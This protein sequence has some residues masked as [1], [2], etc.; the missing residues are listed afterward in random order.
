MSGWCTDPACNTF[1]GVKL[2]RSRG[3]QSDIKPRQ[4]QSNPHTGKETYSES[5]SKPKTTHVRDSHT[6]YT[7]YIVIS[8]IVFIMALFVYYRSKNSIDDD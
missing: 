7:P 8:L 1:Q 6:S 4:P 2:Q 5:S 3:K